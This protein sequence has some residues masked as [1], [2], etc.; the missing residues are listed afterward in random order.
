MTWWLLQNI[1]HYTDGKMFE[2]ALADLA[3]AVGGQEVFGLLV[4]AV[5]M[6]AF[7]LA[8]NG[9]MASVAALTALS[10]GLLI[11]SLPPGFQRVAQVVIFLGLVAAVY[12]L[13]DKFVD[14]TP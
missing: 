2:A 9:G 1:T 6:L 13:I 8:S 10:G 14:S 3:A 12:A 7:Y 11:A 4:G 5:L